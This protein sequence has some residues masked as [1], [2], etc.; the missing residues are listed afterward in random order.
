MKSKIG[1]ILAGTYA[2]IAVSF[3]VYALTCGGMMCGLP[4]ALTVLPWLYLPFSFLSS[5]ESSSLYI[6]QIISTVLLYLIG[7]A[8]TKGIKNR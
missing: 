2:L 4:A 6:Y 1:I 7:L 8:I 5:G 3:D